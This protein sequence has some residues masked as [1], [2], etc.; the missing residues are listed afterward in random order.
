MM[1]KRSDLLHGLN[2]DGAV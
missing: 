1:M 2:H